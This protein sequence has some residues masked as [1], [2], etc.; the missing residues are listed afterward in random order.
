MTE[1]SGVGLFSTFGIAASGVTVQRKWLD[2]IA[3][4]IANINTAR[5]MSGP[6]YQ[7]EYVVARPVTRGGD[8]GGVEVAG[9]ARGSAAGRVV[10]DPTNPL[11]DA[12][13][14]VRL[15]D[16]DL[17]QQMTQ[18]IMAQ[19][20]YQAGLAVVDRARD[21]YAAAIQIGRNS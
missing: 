2:A 14:N 19:R 21:A 5:P 15:P 7:A 20:G 3:D 18:M 13:G 4:N 9:I 17:S 16:V 8:T 11:A 12:N 6:A 1:I 10:N